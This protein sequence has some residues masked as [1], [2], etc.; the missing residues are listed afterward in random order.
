MKKLA[1]FLMI[2]A[3][4]LLVSATASAF[5]SHWYWGKIQGTYAMTATGN[6]LWAPDGFYPNNASPKAYSSHFTAHGIWTFQANGTGKA[7]ITQYGFSAPPVV[8]APGDNH[9]FAVAASVRYRFDFDY[10]MTYKGEIS[11]SPKNLSATFLSGPKAGVTYTAEPAAPIGS[12]VVPEP[13][14]YLG[15]VS[16]EWDYKTLTLNSGNELQKYIFD[17]GE[18]C[19]GICHSARVLIR[20]GY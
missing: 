20:V 6:C 19:Y 13:I 9:Y 3:L 7:E 8:G 2:P 16:K 1:V 4:V 12:T 11:V 18:Q 14:Q 17:N 10:A 5:G 15:M